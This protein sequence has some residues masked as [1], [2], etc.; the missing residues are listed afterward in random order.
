MEQEYLE[1][2]LLRLSQQTNDY[3]G[4]QLA[5]AYKLVYQGCMGPEHAI[6]DE[7]TVIKW[8]DKEW[9][10]IEASSHEGLYSDIA[11][12]AQI[13]R[14]NLRA[15]KSFGISK[16]Q[17]CEEFMDLAKVFPKRP[18]LLR[19]IWKGVSQ[20]IKDGDCIVWNPQDIDKFN[21]EIFK[22]NF[23]A[24]HHSSEYREKN[25]PAYRLIGEIIS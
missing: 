24:V 20:Q 10:S 5:D 16:E 23:P 15:A 14:I 21:I 13:H 7:V 2:T 22:N 12:H 11:I 9:D 25:K 1:K 18:D 8:L 3:E 4:Y 19:T 6:S 17:I